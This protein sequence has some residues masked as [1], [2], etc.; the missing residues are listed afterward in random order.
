MSLKICSVSE[1]PITTFPEWEYAAADGHY[2]F[3]IEQL[4]KDI[5]I[6]RGK[7]TSER[8]DVVQHSR[9]F[10]KIIAENMSKYESY[11][12]IQ[13]FSDVRGATL[14]SRRE[15]ARWLSEEIHRI[16]LVIF[17][18][19]NPL[20]NTLVKLG[21]HLSPRFSN[22]H[23][24]KSYEEAIHKILKH[25]QG[26]SA[27]YVFTKKDDSTRR[28]HQLLGYLSK[29]TWLEDLNQD[30]AHLPLEDPYSDIFR[31][32]EVVQADFRL[33]AKEKQIE[34][35]RVLNEISKR[36]KV[37]D[38]L[39]HSE[40]K[41]ST[42]VNILP[43]AILHLGEKG[44]VLSTNPV[45]EMM[46]GV[47]TKEVLHQ[48]IYDVISIVNLPK[49]KIHFHELLSQNMSFDIETPLFTNKTGEKTDKPL[50]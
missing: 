19:M 23:I 34:H 26:E 50:L 38:K 8:E 25:Q 10:T 20:M 3:R 47:P 49:I 9:L 5:F 42:T 16:H 15:F 37:E 46:M 48:S 17:Y 2:C 30:I 12:M 13:D 24:V 33:I 14:A 44:N 11:Y 35:M 6:S 32:I 4:G 21:K 7:G 40:K 45:F 41:H 1:L 18:G 22:V 31:A 43:I 36:Q 28:I 39:R 29:M 27:E